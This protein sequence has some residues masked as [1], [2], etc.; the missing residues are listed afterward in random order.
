MIVLIFL[1]PSKS[2]HNNHPT[3]ANIEDFSCRSGKTACWP[4]CHST[5]ENPIP[6]EQCLPFP[7]WVCTILCRS[8]SQWLVALKKQ[9]IPICWHQTKAIVHA[10]F[11][12]VISLKVVVGLVLLIKD[13][14]R[15]VVKICLLTLRS[16]WRHR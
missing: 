6:I 1:L 8:H 14:G 4:I 13:G 7:P 2:S 16:S 3:C 15:N 12:V 5:K 9:M 10:P 11:N